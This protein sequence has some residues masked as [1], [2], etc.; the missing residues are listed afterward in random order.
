M[1]SPQIWQFIRISPRSCAKYRTQARHSQPLQAVVPGENGCGWNKLCRCQPD[2][3]CCNSVHTYLVT[4]QP[5]FWEP[6]IQTSAS[7]KCTPVPWALFENAAPRLAGQEWTHKTTLLAKFPLHHME[8]S[9]SSSRFPPPNGE[10]R[11]IHCT[12]VGHCKCWK[13]LKC[14][15]TR[16]QSK[17]YTALKSP[18]AA[19]WGLEWY[20]LQHLEFE[21]KSQGA[22]V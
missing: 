18:M 2:C 8:H 16:D 10:G 6:V 22:E 17:N 15:S 5:L 9:E 4:Q 11:M 13:Q 14:P 7:L 21:Q 12:I 19:L 3:T 20:G 1:A